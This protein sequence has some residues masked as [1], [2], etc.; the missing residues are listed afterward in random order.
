MKKLILSA[1][2]VVSITCSFAQKANV[3]KAKDFALQDKPNFGEARKAI[4]LA[5]VDSTTKSDP[6]TWYVAG[7]IGYTENDALYKKALLNMPYDENAKGKVIVESYKYFLEAD[8]LDQM[9]NEKGKVKPK[10]RKEIKSKI[11]EYYSTSQNLISYGAYLFDKKKDY[12]GAIQAWEVYLAIPKL[13]MMN[14]ELPMDSTYKMIK[15]YSAVAAVN[16]ELHDKAISICNDLKSDNYESLKVYQFL[17]QEYMAKKDT[18]KAI[19]SLKEGFTKFP[20]EA[21][22]LQNLINNFIYSGKTKEALVYLNA[23]IEKEPKMAQYQ[24]VKGN[25]DESLGNLDDARSA[26]DKAIEIDPT[27]ADAYAGI[28][29]LY[30]NKAVKMLQVANET[31]KDNKLFNAEAKKA[32]SVFKESVPFFKKASELKPTEVD[33]KKNLKTLYYKL[34]M[35]AEYDAISKEIEAMK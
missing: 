6:N 5:L 15:Y 7:L 1:F 21:W 33:Y 8:K 12:E 29:R 34:K 17:Y 31:I 2:V 18:V 11:K 32:E 23:A 26:F 14:N 16:G 3:S 30:F 35:N 10:F 9:P 28:G 22:F 27:M 19:N 4:K 13:P 25:L 24:F 20:G